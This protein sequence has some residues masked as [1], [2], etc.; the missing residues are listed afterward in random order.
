MTP[1]ESARE[2]INAVATH[3]AAR[4]EALLQRWREA[5]DADPELTSAPG[6]GI[7]LAIVKRLYELLDASLELH[8]EADKGTTFRVLFP[9]QSPRPASDSG[10]DDSGRL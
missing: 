10:E 6:E 7:G 9:R 4:R 3:L 8:T 5:A 1:E 2:Q